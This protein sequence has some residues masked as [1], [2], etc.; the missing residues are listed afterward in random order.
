VGEG[1]KK[2]LAEAG[3]LRRVERPRPL[4]MNERV[5]EERKMHRF[6]SEIGE[7]MGRVGESNQAEE[8][9]GHMRS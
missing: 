1:A 8:R 5:R 6:K 3:G 9:I 7:L 4:E 2:F